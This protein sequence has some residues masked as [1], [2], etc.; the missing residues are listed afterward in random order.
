M[1]KFYYRI[2][3]AYHE[4]SAE[5]A[6]DPERILYHINMFNSYRHKCREQKGD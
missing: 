4:I 1:K 5:S 6:I 2:M 3:M